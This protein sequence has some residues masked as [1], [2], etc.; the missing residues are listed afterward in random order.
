MLAEISIVGVYSCEPRGIMTKEDSLA[1]VMMVLF[2]F[3]L[4]KTQNLEGDI[5]GVTLLFYLHIRP[6]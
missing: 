6:P 3:P 1:S 5:C 2:P 4:E